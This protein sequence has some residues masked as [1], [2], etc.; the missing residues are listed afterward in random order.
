[1]YHLIYSFPGHQGC[2]KLL[3][4]LKGKNEEAI[5][6]SKMIDKCCLQ[7]SLQSI[8]EARTSSLASITTSNS[9]WGQEQGL[10]QLGSREQILS[11]LLISCWQDISLL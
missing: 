3:L 4:L 11:P 8:Q 6:N 7:G 5:P 1:M 9:G 2:E 10:Q